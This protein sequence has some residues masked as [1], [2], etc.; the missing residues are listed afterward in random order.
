[1][2][3]LKPIRVERLMEELDRRLLDLLNDLAPSDWQ[4]PTVAGQWRVHDVAA[5]LLDGNLRRL[6]IQR[7]QHFRNRL[8]L[9]PVRL[10]RVG[11]LSQST[12]PEM[13]RG[14]SEIESGLDG[15]AVATDG[16]RSPPLPRPIGPARAGAIPGSLGR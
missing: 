9:G 13:D 3:F 12:E 6:A 14:R 16:S 15:L 5:H 4:R 7:D 8:E 1:M 2:E 11:G 10:S